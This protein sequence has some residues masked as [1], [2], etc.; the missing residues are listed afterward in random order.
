MGRKSTI[1]DLSAE[2]RGYLE[3]QTRARTIQQR[4]Y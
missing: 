1:I 3:T 4:L 2:D